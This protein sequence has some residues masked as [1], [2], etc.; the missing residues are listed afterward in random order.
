MYGKGKS[1]SSVPSDSQA[2]EKAFHFGVFANSF[3]AQEAESLGLDFS[4][5]KAYVL[6]ERG[7]SEEPQSGHLLKS[8]DII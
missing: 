1:N 8:K 5:S 2:R 4:H 7:S 6:L 3:G